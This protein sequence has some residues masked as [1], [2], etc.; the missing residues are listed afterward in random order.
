M[1]YALNNTPHISIN[2]QMQM[3]AP[4]IWRIWNKKEGWWWRGGGG[5]CEA[6]NIC[7]LVMSAVALMSSRTICF[8]TLVPL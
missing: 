1:I 4:V 5:N 6:A 3:V 8:P 7:R 2:Q